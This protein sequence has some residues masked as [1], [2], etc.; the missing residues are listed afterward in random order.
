MHLDPDGPDRIRIGIANSGPGI[1]TDYLDKIFD[2]LYTTKTNGMGIGIQ[3][4]RSIVEALDGELRAFNRPG[5]GAV[6]EF[7]LN[8]IPASAETVAAG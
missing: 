6:F 7:S 3:I 1:P 4:C 2:P 8:T 5:G